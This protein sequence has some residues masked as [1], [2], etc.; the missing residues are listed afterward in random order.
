MKRF[1]E[2]MNF[3][4]KK[5]FKISILFSLFMEIGILFF[6][7]LKMFQGKTKPKRMPKKYILISD[8]DTARKALELRLN[9]KVFL[10]KTIE[11]TGFNS[12]TE[13]ILDQNFIDFKTIINVLETHKN[14]GFTFKIGSKSF[15]FSIGSN[16]SFDRG[17]IIQTAVF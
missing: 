4:Y 5:H 1:R 6:S 7:F 15:D 13:I 17:E 14:K 9:Q 8:N 16:S 3:F 11:L 10:Q 12:N 2:A